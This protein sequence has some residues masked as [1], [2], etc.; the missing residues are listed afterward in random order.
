M[1][2][3]L[4]CFLFFF[5]FFF[6][7]ED[8]IRD[9]YVTGVQTCALPIYL[10]R[11]QRQSPRAIGLHER[12]PAGRERHA[13]EGPRGGVREQARHLGRVEQRHLGH[14]IE[15]RR[16]ERSEAGGAE[17][18]RRL[19]AVLDAALDAPYRL[20][21]AHPGDVGGLAR[22]GRDGA[23]AR[24]DQHEVRRALSGRRRR[25]RPRAVGQ[26]REQRGALARGER[27]RALDEVHEARIERG[28]G[29][30]DRAQT[31]EELRSAKRRE[32]RSP[33]NAENARRLLHF[34]S[35]GGVEY[36]GIGNCATVALPPSITV[37]LAAPC[38]FTSSM[39]RIACIGRKVRNTP[40]N[41]PLMRSSAGSRTTEERSPNSSSSTSMNPNSSPWL[42]L[43]A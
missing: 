39:R 26:E 24:H 8:G 1:L 7:A 12:R 25:L 33:R 21:P 35:P 15:E 17:G 32:R 28:H 43:R 10:L 27:S 34:F 20:E 29:R 42:T 19:E 40:E 3:V 2:F 37:I 22:P 23:G 18:A 6:Q 5:F 38:F 11:R 41:S 14:A 30:L 4:L 9:L 16:R 36:T 13:L 31:L